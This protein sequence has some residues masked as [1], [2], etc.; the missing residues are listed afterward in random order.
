MS[1]PVRE[2]RK[3]AQQIPEPIH[4]D[5]TAQYLSPITNVEHELGRAEQYSRPP[6]TVYDADA[7]KKL[8]T[9]TIRIDK[10]L[11]NIEDELLGE[12]SDL[13]LCE[14]LQ[15]EELLARQS[16]DLKVKIRTLEWKEL[17]RSKPFG[18]S[19]DSMET[20]LE[21]CNE[22]GNITSVVAALSASIAIT[23]LYSAVRG[24][25]FYFFAAWWCSIISLTSGIAL[26]ILSTKYTRKI[27]RPLK[28][29]DW[30]RVHVS[31]VITTICLLG[32]VGAIVAMCYGAIHYDLSVELQAGFPPPHI[33]D[34]PSVPTVPW[35]SIIVASIIISIIC[36]GAFF[37]LFIGPFRF[38]LRR[39]WDMRE[40][41]GLHE[42]DS[43]RHR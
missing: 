36:G 42:K 10:A 5:Y 15:R 41:K 38:S 25:M 34:G 27:S 16:D 14:C 26:S 24:N 35:A 40:Q 37:A 9:M 2:Q 7:M 6:S 21:I 4:R 30:W 23:I 11:E 8:R 12:L 32:V 39:T 33:Q 18:F 13:Q 19:P 1:M 29:W 43:R 17:A 22:V 28:S 20:V 31:G 3:L